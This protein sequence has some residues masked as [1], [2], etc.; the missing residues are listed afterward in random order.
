M[1]KKETKKIR[2]NYVMTE[3]EWKELKTIQDYTN[4]QQGRGGT[5]IGSILRRLVSEEVRR[6]TEEE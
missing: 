1:A 4:K 6:I 2:F 3:T 5:T